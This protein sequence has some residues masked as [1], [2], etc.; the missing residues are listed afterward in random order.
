MST[1]DES[2]TRSTHHAYSTPEDVWDAK[3]QIAFILKRREGRDAA[4]SSQ[5]LAD[6]TGQIAATT[7]RD[8]I[9]ELRREEGLPV[10]ACQDGY[11]LV[12]DVSGLER[13]LDRIAGE[14]ETRKE[15]RG[16]LVSSFNQWKK[17]E[18]GDD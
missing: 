5:A 7:A 9:K 1:D 4:I 15:T 11:Y 3:R 17:R 12:R 2:T 16:E 18:C 6:A 8:C 13:E 14:I 10:V